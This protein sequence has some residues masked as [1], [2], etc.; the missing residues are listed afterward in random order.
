MAGK[1]IAHNRLVFI[2]IARSIAILMMLEGHFI[3]MALTDE[4]RGSEH[5][6]YEAWR[7]TRGLTAPLFFT[8]SGLVFTYLLVRKEEPFFSN[9]RVKKGLSRVVKLILWG[10]ALQLNLL[11]LLKGE[12]SG[13][14]Y[15]FHVLQ[16]IGLSLFAVILLYGF[17]RLIKVVPFYVILGLCGIFAFIIK[18]T[19]YALDFS[20]MHPFF[21]N[22]FVVTSENRE[23]KSIFPIIPW[24]GFTLLGAM[25]GSFVSKRPQHV[26]TIWFPSILLILA[27]VLNT[28][29]ELFI[30]LI[31]PPLVNLGLEPFTGLG[32]LFARFGQ[33][34]LILAV[35]IIVGK[36]KRYLRFLYRRKLTFLR[37]WWIPV[38]FFVL[39]AVALVYNVMLTGNGKPDH[40]SLLGTLTLGALGQFLIFIGIVITSAK[41]IHWNY[42]LFIKIGQNTLSIY[43]VHVIILYAG[44]FGFGLNTI[45]DRNLG[46]WFSIVGAIGFML[47]FTYFVKYLE[48]IQGFYKRL[49][50]RWWLNR[51]N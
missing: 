32:Y 26:Y 41:L 44:L 46:P 35:I 22:I 51:K 12:F 36:Y 34:L 19:I 30:Q 33:V 23:F 8:V 39:G 29:P 49:F 47:F 17:Q 15:V 6:F 45:L 10:Y 21:E 18:P 31:Q 13:F 4:Y 48:E 27:V 25:I 2:D 14:L 1:K 50:P 11:Y 40:V 24:V 3:V 42:D 38:G 5:F 9:V 37:T 43:I 7:F 28:L 20:S 16:C